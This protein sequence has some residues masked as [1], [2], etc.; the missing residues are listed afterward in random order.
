VQR[1]TVDVT[2]CLQIAMILF[3]NSAFWLRR[4]LRI[5]RDES[6]A[7]DLRAAAGPAAVEWTG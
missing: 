5:C 2:E 7:R 6:A 1:A 4:A 3:S